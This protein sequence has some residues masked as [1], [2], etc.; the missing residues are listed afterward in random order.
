[1]LKIERVFGHVVTSEVGPLDE[2]VEGVGATDIEG[3]DGAR[4]ADVLVELRRVRAKLAAVEARLVA[5]VETARA[6]TD[7][8][9]LTAASWLAASD[10]DEV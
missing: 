2:A 3:M 7:E 6:W 10:H 9:Y 4:A 1:M 5:R 8:G